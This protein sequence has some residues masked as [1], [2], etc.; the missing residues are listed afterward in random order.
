MN[1]SAKMYT[2]AMHVLYWLGPIAGYVN[3]RGMWG[4]SMCG[5]CGLCQC[6]GY[7]GY[8]NVRGMWG[9]KYIDERDMWGTEY[10]DEPSL[11]MYFLLH[12]LLH[13]L[14]LF[15]ILC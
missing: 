3:A 14:T 11:R 9:M 5:V 2:L 12:L 1:L 7:V 4:I 10:V 8:F 6:A 13:S 15:L